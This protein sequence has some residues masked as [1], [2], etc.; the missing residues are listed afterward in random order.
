MNDFHLGNTT[1]I[2]QG[3]HKLPRIFFGFFYHKFAN[4]YDGITYLIS[5][6]LWKTWLETI[7]SLLN[8][9]TILEIGFGPG[10]LQYL[11]KAK[12]SEC[13][14]L[15]ESSQMGY[16]ASG[17]LKSAGYTPLLTRAVGES[18]PYSNAVFDQVVTTFP[19]EFITKPRTLSEIRR[20]LKDD[21]ELLI[22]RFAWLS[23]QKWPYK[24]TAWLFQLVGE[25][26]A[27]NQPLQY[28]RL[29]APFIEAGF[30]VKVQ[31]VDLESS[32]VIIFHCLNNPS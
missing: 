23:D 24:L 4:F 3:F 18:I 12:E 16:L 27:K 8:G 22:L 1:R 19:A 13:F 10:H 7:S 9:S 29:S 2:R 6:G 21:G 17:R 5:M 28:E 31:Q 25:A 15:D 11:L 32:G 14:G 20:V 30:Q 26:P